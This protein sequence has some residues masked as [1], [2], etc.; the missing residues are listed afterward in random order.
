[1]DKQQEELAMRLDLKTPYKWVMDNLIPNKSSDVQERWKI[2]SKMVEL[3]EEWVEE[4]VNNG[5]LKLSDVLHDFKG[6][7]SE[8]EHFLP[9]ISTDK[10]YTF[11]EVWDYIIEH[12][13][14]TENELRL[15]CNINGSSVDNLQEV[16]QVRTGYMDMEQHTWTLNA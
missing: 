9:R 11:D 8:D 3:N 16:I 10:E 6:I 4:V 15:V 13:I 5:E 2:M 12:D 7:Y 14:A 1:M